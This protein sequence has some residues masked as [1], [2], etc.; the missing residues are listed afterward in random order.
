MKT[1]K[2]SQEN[3]MT[4][5]DSVSGVSWV[6]DRKMY[7]DF[8]SSIALSLSLFLSNP[9]C[10]L[11][12]LL[13]FSFW[14]S[15]CFLLRWLLSV[16]PRFSLPMKHIMS[17]LLFCSF[18]LVNDFWEE[19][20]LFSPTNSPAWIPIFILNFLLTPASFLLPLFD[21]REDISGGK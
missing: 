7:T 12:L 5:H 18:S 21:A 16:L 8:S 19:S 20:A 4:T 3:S 11:S 9:F 2:K 13:S 10:T 6:T 14:F 1:K 17:G 15:W